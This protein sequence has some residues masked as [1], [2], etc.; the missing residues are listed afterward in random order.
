MNLIAPW[1]VPHSSSGALLSP[2]VY[3]VCILMQPHAF[4]YCFMLFSLGAAPLVPDHNFMQNAGGLTTAALTK[5]HCWSQGMRNQYT[6]S[7]KRKIRLTEWIKQHLAI[8]RWKNSKALP[9]PLSP[10]THVSYPQEPHDTRV[11]RKQH[12]FEKGRLAHQAVKSRGNRIFLFISN[13]Q[14][15]ISSFSKETMAHMHTAM[16]SDVGIRQRLKCQ[17]RSST[18]QQ[19]DSA[20]T[21]AG[22]DGAALLQS[23]LS[24]ER[25]QQRSSTAQQT[26]S[27]QTWAGEASA[28]LLQ[29]M[30]SHLRLPCH[31]GRGGEA[32]LQSTPSAPE[33]F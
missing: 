5:I 17:Q 27:A 32:P 24:R 21:W 13:I 14:V 33:L 31:H 4:I 22:E 26:D 10:R 8:Y 6:L 2:G 1:W 29:S 9:P 20:Q 15:R 18:A 30:L 3:L 7:S 16:L 23:T 11:F 12:D 25:M 28:A 19:T